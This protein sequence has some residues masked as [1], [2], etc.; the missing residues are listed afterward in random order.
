MHIGL[1]TECL[2]KPYTGVEIQTKALVEGLSKTP[3]TITCF[4]FDDSRHPKLGK[5]NHYLFH[6]PPFRVP[7]YQ[8]I[9]SLF[10]HRCF[11]HLDVL[12]LQHPQVPYVFKPSVPVVMTIHDISP[13]FLPH[14]HNTRRVVFFRNVLPFYLRRVGAVLASSESTKSDL[15]KYYNIPE[16]KIHVVHLAL[17]LK[18]SAGKNKEPF[19]LYVGTLEP[20]K[21]V[22]GLVRAYAI[23][24]SQGF[25]Q[26]LV[27]AGMKGWKYENIFR[28]IEQHNLQN[29]VIYK[30]YV[31]EDEKEELYKKAEL[32]VWPSFYE[33][34]GLPVLEAMA[35]GTPVVTSRSSSLPEVV[36]DAGVLVNP[37]SPEDIARGVR[38]ALSSPARYKKMVREGLKR[39]KLFTVKKMVK[40][41]LAV[42]EGVVQK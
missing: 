42:Y 3:H 5:V 25:K 27:I 18:I 20:R 9:A 14:F 37:N 24:K 31:S 17:P 2:T 28:L 8:T 19:I 30:G 34:F 33:G 22:E 40:E 10:R 13:V 35:R 16:E 36:G 6:K 7:L 11:S 26:K 12:H 29:D 15:I 38:E 4:H 21:N 23:L 41:T 1:Y 39:A 32:F